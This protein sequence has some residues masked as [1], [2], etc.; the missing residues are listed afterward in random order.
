ML[1]A[2]DLDD[3]HPAR[4]EAGQLRL[5]AEGRD[6][7]PVVAADLED[8]LALEALD[9]P[10]VDLDP[11]P[12]RRLRPLRR[13]GREQ[14]LGERVVE[15]LERCSSRR[16]GEA[17]R[18]VIV[19]SVGCAGGDRDRPAD[20]GRARAAQDVLVELG[21]EVS[22]PAREREGR[23]ALVV[24]QGGADDV[25]A[26]G[27]P[28][29]GGRSAAGRPVAI[30]SPISLTPAQADPARD[31]LAARLVGAEAGQEPGQVD[32]AGPLVGGDDRAR[33]D[34]GAD[35][36]QGVELVRRVERAR[37]AGCPPDGPPTSDAP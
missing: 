19:S 2:L 34:V 30:R 13:L 22:H 37:P 12:R 23:Q 28:G 29:A 36:A 25:G 7:D 20:A 16:R 15:R 1:L 14:A 10:A 26:T 4:P 5:V 3:A 8:R 18:S 33:A 9:D 21:P 24:A 35:R 17:R 11:D 31:R 6:L 27:R 32:D